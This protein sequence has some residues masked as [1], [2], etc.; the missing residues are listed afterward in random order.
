MNL[1]QTIA[2]IDPNHFNIREQSLERLRARTKEL[3]FFPLPLSWNDIEC[4]WISLEPN[5]QHKGKKIHFYIEYEDD[6]YIMNIFKEVARY[7]EKG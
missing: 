5:E 4:F 2:E 6:P 7:E 3:G 1:I